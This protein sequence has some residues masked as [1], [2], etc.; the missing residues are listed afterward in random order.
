MQQTMQNVESH[1]AF[2]IDAIG[3]RLSRSG[4]RA[5]DDFPVLEGEH[6]GRAGD[7]A[8]LFV[9]LRHALVAHDGDENCIRDTGRGTSARPNQGNGE[10][11]ERS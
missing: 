8:K 6:I 1:L 4:R 7:A 2:D 11:R 10:S 3:A 5:D 9:Q